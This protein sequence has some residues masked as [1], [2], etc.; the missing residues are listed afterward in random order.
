[1]RNIAVDG[2]KALYLD[3]QRRGADFAQVLKEQAVGRDR[4]HRPR[5]RRQPDLLREPD[6]RRAA[7]P[8]DVRRTPRSRARVR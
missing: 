7:G 2:V 6:A 3:L 8:G 5:S 1:V 4:L